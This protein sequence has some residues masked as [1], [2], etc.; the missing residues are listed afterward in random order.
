VDT[1]GF[2]D[3]FVYGV[4]DWPEI[5]G[6]AADRITA[7]DV[8][9]IKKVASDEPNLEHKVVQIEAIRADKARV[10]VGGADSTGSH[11]N[12]YVVI[13]RTGRWMR[14]PFSE[15]EN[16]RTFAGH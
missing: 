13:K 5:S 7:D 4:R 8:R 16:E 10:K 3:D 1:F 9:Q 11:Y 12:K 15:L 2:A 14:D 6:P